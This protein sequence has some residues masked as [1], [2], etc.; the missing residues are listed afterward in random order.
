MFS[1]HKTQEPLMSALDGAKQ[2]S[3]VLWS[4]HSAQEGRQGR[5]NLLSKSKK[6]P[7][8]HLLHFPSFK[9]SF[10]LHKVHSLI[11]AHS[12]QLSPQGRHVSNSSLYIVPS[13][14]ASH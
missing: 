7:V 2:M 6:V 10:G 9:V 11:V 8:S 1:V 4:V 3:H 5:H 14:H 12:M 13:G